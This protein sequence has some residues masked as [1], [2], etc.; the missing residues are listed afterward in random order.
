[1]RLQELEGFTYG[2]VLHINLGYYNIRLDAAASEMY[3]IIFPLGKCSYN[4]LFMEFGG[5]V[6]IFQAQMIDLMASLHYVRAYIDDLL[7]IAR[8]TI[9]DRISKIDSAHSTA[10]RRT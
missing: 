3:T 10:R 5:S 6:D 2:T 8:G 9:E 7:I 4:R 1:L